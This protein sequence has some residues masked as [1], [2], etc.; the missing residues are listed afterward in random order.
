MQLYKKISENQIKFGLQSNSKK[1]AIREVANILKGDKRIKDFQAFL[2]DVYQR[3][4]LNTTAI[5]C[6]VALPHARTNAV[7]DF[8]IA[9]GVSK[10]GVDFDASDGEPV[11]LIFVIGTP[12][13][14]QINY[15]LK[16][17]AHLTRLLQKE[18]F[19]Q[20]LLNASSASEVIECFHRAED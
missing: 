14:R 10:E 6:S 19:R 20:S 3:E 4:D 16:I 11:K 12:H 18:S 5:G 13:E 9:L 2:N 7:D 17:L 8:I 1:A 15:Y